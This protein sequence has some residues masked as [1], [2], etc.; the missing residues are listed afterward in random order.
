MVHL[1]LVNKWKVR[2]EACFGVGGAHE[3][4]AYVI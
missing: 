2:D 1:K 4:A 3:K